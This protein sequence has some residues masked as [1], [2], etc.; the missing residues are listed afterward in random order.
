MPA[1]RPPRFLKSV[2]LDVIPAE[3]GE[4]T[5]GVLTVDSDRG[6]VEYMITAESAR[7][8]RTTMDQFLDYGS[9]VSGAGQ[10]GPQQEAQTLTVPISPASITVGEAEVGGQKVGVLQI[11]SEDGR[12]ASLLLDEGQAEFII[13]AATQLQAILN[14]TRQ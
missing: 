6:I 4:E 11:Q 14:Q 3:P 2:G 1:R 12:E 7:A 8:F 10:P 13:Q 9:A 5:L